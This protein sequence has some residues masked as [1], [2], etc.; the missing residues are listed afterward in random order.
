MAC[1]LYVTVLQQLGFDVGKFST[2]ES[3]L[4]SVLT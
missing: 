2:S 1:D 3:D 4:N